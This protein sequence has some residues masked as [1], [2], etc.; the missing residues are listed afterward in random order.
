MT[1]KELGYLKHNIN[2]PL[3]I[4]KAAARQSESKELIDE[5][6]KRITECLNSIKPEGEVMS[7][8]ERTD[9]FDINRIVEHKDDTALKYELEATFTSCLE[10]KTV[11]LVELII[12][13]EYERY[14]FGG[15]KKYTETVEV[16]DLVKNLHPE[17]FE[18]WEEYMIS[19][20]Q[21]HLNDAIENKVAV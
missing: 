6:I 3:Q 19:E 8:P 5:Q 18:E 1:G 17:L 9:T 2:N 11:A 15:K 20:G 4:I 21:K 10:E 14:D 13:R 7:L 12:L 16:T